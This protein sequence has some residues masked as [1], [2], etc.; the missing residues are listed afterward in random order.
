MYICQIAHIASA[1]SCRHQQDA[2]A[3]FKYVIKYV[4]RDTMKKS[5][6]QSKD[7]KFGPRNFMDHLL[8]SMS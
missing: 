4:I 2:D 5:K 7:P 6:L 1:L 3:K 8:Y